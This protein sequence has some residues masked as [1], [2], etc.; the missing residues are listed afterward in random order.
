MTRRIV[1]LAL[2]ASWPLVALPRP[3]PAAEDPFAC[4]GGA[5]YLAMQYGFSCADLPALCA[6]ARALL[7][8]AGHDEAAAER[9]ARGRGYGNLSIS[10]A[11]HYCRRRP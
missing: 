6:T 3:A 9:L 10:L 2:A 5:R 11:R 7:A 8:E 1:L 4:F